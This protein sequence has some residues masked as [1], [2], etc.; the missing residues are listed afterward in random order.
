MSDRALKK[1]YT[2]CRQK[3]TQKNQWSRV[4]AVEGVINFEQAKQTQSQR[5]FAKQSGIPRGTLQHWINRKQSLDASPTVID[6]CESPEG[7]AFIHQLLT[8]AH[9]AL[10]KDG[11]ASIHSMS[12]FINLS[13]L[14]SFVA[15]SY[16]TQ[17]LISSRMDHAIIEFGETEQQRLGASMR[18]KKITL[19]EDETF[20]PQTCLVSIEPGSNFI[21]AEKYT[22]D[23]KGET[24]TKLIKNALKGLSVDVV[25]IT[26]DEGTGLLNHTLK[27]LG[28][29]HSPD[30]FHVPH[31]IIKGTSGALASQVKKTKKAYEQSSH[32]VDKLIK[33]IHQCLGSH[34]KSK[35]ILHQKLEQK[36]NEA[37][38]QEQDDLI[39]FECA[40]KDQ[41][42]VKVAQSEIGKVYHPYNIKTGEEQNSEKVSY[43][44]DDCFVRVNNAITHLSD[45]CKSR[46]SKAQR[47]VSKMT[48][49]ISF[50]FNMVA[51]YLE[52]SSFSFIEKEQI[53]TILLPGY[54]LQ[55]VAKREK[56]KGRQAEIFK[57]SE[58]L[59]INFHQN[60]HYYQFL[61]EE[62]K[63][64]MKKAAIE[65]V[66][67][68]QRSSSC[69]EGRNAQLSLRHHGL[70]RL[71]EQCL[72]AQTV[73]HNYY[74]T[75]KENET[76]AE[77]FFEAQHEDLF[78]YIL[79]K[80]DYPARP[81]KHRQIAA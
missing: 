44:L 12:K 34:K 74:R 30:C 16:S 63:Q 69:V 18:R 20:H 37:F 62:K 41:K 61:S 39:F 28:V 45:V 46:V 29:H 64:Q 6:F 70:H 54:Y 4:A 77:R 21:I 47:V 8:A 78:Q 7:L 75:N 25:Q 27:G 52:N 33:K 79:K 3:S 67:I 36:L 17:R 55:A 14:A 38:E 43:L 24:W 26:S 76:P 11:I 81:R 48:L 15:S 1:Y 68:F 60:N 2:D 58:Q 65:C 10:T 71:S 53:E 9:F 22:E 59:L 35:K 32:Q 13:G 73:I 5:E 57:Q 80:M 42:S 49:T 72:K 56:N 19:A 31:E 66:Q 40:L 23:R 51:L 50:F